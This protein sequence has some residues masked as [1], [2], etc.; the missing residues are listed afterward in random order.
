MKS[1]SDY[2]SKKGSKNK[3]GASSSV[4]EEQANIPAKKGMNSAK[5]LTNLVNFAKN[6]KEKVKSGGK[7][8][9]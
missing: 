7:K 1:K 9:P 8:K 2:F 5:S 6:T 3:R 4:D